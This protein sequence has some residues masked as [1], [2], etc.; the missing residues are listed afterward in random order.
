MQLKRTVYRQILLLLCLQISMAS[1]ARE[2][3]HGL[4]TTEVISSDDAFRATEKLPK[5]QKAT[6]IHD[7]LKNAFYPLMERIHDQG[8]KIT[9]KEILEKLR[10]YQATN[11]I[12]ET[13]YQIG[14]GNTRYP[15]MNAQSA[16]GSR[17]QGIVQHS[18]STGNNQFY[19]WQTNP[20]FA[21]HASNKAL[22]IEPSQNQVKDFG[23]F[24]QMLS[25]SP[26]PV[27]AYGQKFSAN[28][29][30]TTQIMM[31][32]VGNDPLLREMATKAYQ[33]NLKLF[34]EEVGRVKMASSEETDPKTAAVSGALEGILSF[35]QFL[36]NTL[37]EKI[38]GAA[39][40]ADALRMIVN[41]SA[42]Q[43]T[44]LV[45]EFTSRLTMGLNAPLSISGYYL[46]SVYQVEPNG[47]LSLTA[48]L[49]E[50]LAAFAKKVVEHPRLRKGRCPM[51]GLF[52][53][54]NLPVPQFM[55]PKVETAEIPQAVAQTE[56][57]PPGLQL[58]AE[59]YLRIFTIVNDAGNAQ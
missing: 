7:L 6:V 57:A 14:Y 38:D 3:C 26:T 15:I 19:S 34:S 43:K 33:Q 17:T 28:L 54:M 5:Q 2:L 13:Q 23:I 11:P 42:D 4:F 41:N 48:Q 20:A 47:K 35:H 16:W 8:Q 22:W 40:G 58:L 56:F 59:T 52:K 37:G 44:G 50:T 39:T 18:I 53:R 24:F 10:H 31:E 32:L 27:N 12:N 55:H 21:M 46:K 49:K 51:A 30:R 9:A 36:S 1:H 29:L 45:A 25:T